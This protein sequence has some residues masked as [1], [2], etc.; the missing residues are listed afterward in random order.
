MRAITPA[1][2]LFVPSA[3]GL[4]H[5]PGEHTRDADVIN[6]ANTLL[7]TLLILAGRGG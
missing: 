4:S 1:A 5:Q 7:H 2:M 6:G 3:G